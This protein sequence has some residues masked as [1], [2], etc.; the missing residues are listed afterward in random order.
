MSYTIITTTNA[1]RDVQDA[2]EWENYR[3]SGLARRFL[4]NLNQKYEKVRCVVIDVFPYLI[5]YTIDDENHQVFILRI[6][7]T[8]RKPIW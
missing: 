4:H 6:L 1:R 5:H 7:N 3:K 8:S 2:I